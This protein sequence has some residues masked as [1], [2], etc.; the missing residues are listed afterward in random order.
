VHDRDSVTETLAWYE[1]GL[2][3]DVAAPRRRAPADVR[4]YVFS[5]HGM[6]PIRWTY[7][8]RT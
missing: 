4:L 6:T 1:A 3:R 2:R 8:L 7:D 5:D